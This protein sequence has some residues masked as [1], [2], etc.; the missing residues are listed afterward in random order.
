LESRLTAPGLVCG[1]QK[2]AKVFFEQKIA[3]VT[4]VFGVRAYGARFGV[5][6]N[7]EGHK[8]FF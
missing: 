7:T 4:K 8:D 1:K 6:E 3:K 5:R 2:D